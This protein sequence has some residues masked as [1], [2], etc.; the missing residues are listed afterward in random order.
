[1][2]EPS[3]EGKGPP[4]PNQ[5]LL[6]Y[7]LTRLGEVSQTWTDTFATSPAINVP[8]Y[9][10]LQKLVNTYSAAKVLQV[11]QYAAEKKIVPQAVNAM[12]LAVALCKQVGT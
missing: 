5:D 6:E 4:L 1:M 12:P 2:A 9:R 8:G 11:F 10:A 7:W 3:T